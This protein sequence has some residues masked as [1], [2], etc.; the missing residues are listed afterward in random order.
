MPHVD[1][2][3]ASFHRPAVVYSLSF[4]ILTSRTKSAVHQLEN[5]RHIHRVI[6]T[7]RKKR[8]A[9]LLKAGG[10]GT[11]AKFQR[12][13][14]TFSCLSSELKYWSLYCSVHAACLALCRCA[15]EDH[16]LAHLDDWNPSTSINVQAFPDSFPAG[17][18]ARSQH[19]RRATASAGGKT[20]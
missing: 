18:S 9:D 12:Q 2:S 16:V 1:S 4:R 19:H 14:R 7:Q 11:Q 10:A 5:H 13:V 3:S 17:Q 8:N 20:A 6:S 15:C